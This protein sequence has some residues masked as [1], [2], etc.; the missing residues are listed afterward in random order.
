MQCDT[1]ES[2]HPLGITSLKLRIHK[3]NL[4][5]NEKAEIRA[6]V[7]CFKQSSL[8]SVECLQIIFTAEISTWI[9]P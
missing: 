3:L 8:N 5:R 1:G 9:F 6:A 7:G 2:K 4:R